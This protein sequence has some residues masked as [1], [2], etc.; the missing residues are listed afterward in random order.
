MVTPQAR[1]ILNDIGT[2][3]LAHLELVGSMVRQLIMQTMEEVFIQ[4]PLQATH[5]QQ[6]IFNQ[7]GTL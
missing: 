6:H 2:E 1:A 4:C 7:K 3:E 5:L